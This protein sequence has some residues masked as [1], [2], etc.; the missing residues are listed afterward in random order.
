MPKVIG[1]LSTVPPRQTKFD[2][3]GLQRCDDACCKD[4]QCTQCEKE[5]RIMLKAQKVGERVK[6]AAADAAASVNEVSTSALKVWLN[7]HKRSALTAVEQ[8][9]RQLD[10]NVARDPY[11]GLDS[12]TLL[13]KLMV[14]KAVPKPVAKPVAKVVAKNVV[15]RGHSLALKAPP[16]AD[17]SESES[18]FDS[19]GHHVPASA[20]AIG[21]LCHIQGEDM[22]GQRNICVDC[23]VVSRIVSK[24]TRCI[25][26]YWLKPLYDLDGQV[27]C[28]K[29]CEVFPTWNALIEHQ[30]KLVVEARI[31]QQQLAA[32]QAASDVGNAISSGE[33]KAIASDVDALIEHQKQI[34]VE[35]LILHQLAAGQTASDVGNAISS[36][37]AKAI[38]SDVA[39]PITDESETE[40][41]SEA[42]GQHDAESAFAIGHTC[43]IQGENETTSY[44]CVVTGRIVSK[45]SRRIMKYFVQIAGDETRCVRASQCFG[46]WGAFIQ[47]NE[48]L[49][50]C[51]GSKGKH[52]MKLHNKKGNAS[53][54]VKASASETGPIVQLS[55]G[56]ESSPGDAP[57][58]A[59]GGGGGEATAGAVRGGGDVGGKKNTVWCHKSRLMLWRLILKRNPWDPKWPSKEEAWIAIA[60][61]MHTVTKGHTVTVDDKKGKSKTLDITVHTD[62]PGL[63]V[64]YRRISD[65]A[66][67]GEKIE[68]QK[69]GQTG[70][71][72]EEEQMEMDCVMGIKNYE[73]QGKE[74]AEQKKDLKDKLKHVKDVE[75]PAAVLEQACKTGPI[76]DKV[77]TELQ[78]RRRSLELELAVY[79]KSGKA[80]NLTDAQKKEA[81]ALDAILAERKAKGMETESSDH[82]KP[83]MA[84]TFAHLGTVLT[85]LTQNLKEAA[86]ARAPVVQD[87]AAKLA[88][89]RQDVESGALPITANEEAEMRR[90][91][92]E[93][94]ACS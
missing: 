30:K 46:S 74:F 57:G 53:A 4:F 10:D 94:Y 33:A 59:T 62:G 85:E 82:K 28:V 35:A 70:M 89:L 86:P 29:A 39:E 81:A 73:K 55:S 22:F 41:E 83:K 34:V 45:S 7:A 49:A 16:P 66:A 58:T 54:K 78:K 9:V 3:N 21:G 24:K 56:D 32:G 60:Q 92:L 71:N 2:G 31:L 48:K 93:S 68:S 69:S 13:S 36:D 77:F 40:S 17:V 80:H 64:F 79:Q 44:Q 88:K 84:E 42:N 26:K 14:A 76:Q 72:G 91:I 37:V 47:H 8:E 23:N 6:T 19:S 11:A 87:V 27:C 51:G 43:T 63:F 90:V 18:E 61:E 65:K 38:A 50:E 5:S 75:I 15:K 67:K 52:R 25:T 1:Y 12:S 20:F